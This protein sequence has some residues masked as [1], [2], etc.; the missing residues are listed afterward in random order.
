MKLETIC[1][2]G[3]AGPDPTTLSRGVP[4]YRTSSYVF[5]SAEHAQN[6]FAL[7]ELG[8]IY[9]RLMNPTTDVLEKRVALLEGAPEPA[10]LAVASGM[11]AI[12]Y[13]I[14]N[15]AQA[16]DNI[17]SA[18]NL[19]GGTYTQFHDI[20]PPLGIQVKFV[21]SN[22]PDN[23]AKA[24]DSNTRALFCETVSNPALEVTDLEAVAKVAHD[25][26]LPLVVDSTFSTPYLA[27]PLDHG[28]D[29]VVHALTKWLGGHGAGIGGV[30]VD[31]GRF[32]WA[33]GRHPLYTVP[34]TSYHGLR[35]GID[36]PEP[37]APLA[38][39]LRMRTVPL[40]NLGA[41]ISPDNS[42]M[43]LQGIETLP[44]RME[45]HCDNALAVA[46]HLAAHPK[47]AWVR[48][49]GLE[50]DPMHALNEKYLKGKGGAMVVFGIRGGAAA[51]S[52]FIDSLKL[53][54]HLA[55]VGDAKSLA[56]HPATTTHAQLD[57]GQQ[58]EGGIT[59]DLVRLSVGIEHIDDI[60]ADIDQ[61][62]EAATA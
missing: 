41:C 14:I 53:F 23:F 50:G 10:G 18:R 13:S 5:K 38:Y 62:L 45:R 54:S 24:I 30:V 33:G 29:V 7:K 17:V 1:L 21:D 52:K 2:H 9:T 35:W 31:S 55:N 58:R 25:H 6:L 40:R 8:N 12:F 60:L 43:F 42:W 11:S 34:D 28:A 22:D 20:L 32:N 37:L 19:Y 36:L 61:A 51:G 47:A 44:L 15:L 16:G 57:E 56:I 59:P 39:I 27:R 26:G 48:Y 3:G 4:V 49:P 46:K